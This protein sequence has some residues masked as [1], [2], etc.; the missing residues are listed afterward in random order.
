MRGF[1]SFVRAN[2]RDMSDDPWYGLLVYSWVLFV[3]YE[4]ATRSGWLPC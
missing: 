2:L 3:G 1:A 4:V